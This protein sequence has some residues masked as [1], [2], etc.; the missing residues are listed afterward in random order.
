MVCVGVVIVRAIVEVFV[1]KIDPI[2][3]IVKSSMIISSSIKHTR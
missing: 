3:C 1:M 2:Q